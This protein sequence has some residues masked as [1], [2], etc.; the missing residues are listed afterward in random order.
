MVLACDCAGGV[1]ITVCGG[2]DDP[3]AARANN[4]GRTRHPVRNPRMGNLHQFG[5]MEMNNERAGFG[6]L[7]SQGADS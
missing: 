4:P 3:H 6:R 7:V 1:T 5:W 2:G